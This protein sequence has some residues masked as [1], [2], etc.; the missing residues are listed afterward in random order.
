[1]PFILKKRPVTDPVLGR[2]AISRNGLMP[3][4]YRQG[5]ALRDD[6]RHS[7]KRLERGLLFIATTLILHNN[8]AIGKTISG[9]R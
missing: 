4:R 5:W 7:W 3:V 9:L 1:M 8:T 6:I 2:L